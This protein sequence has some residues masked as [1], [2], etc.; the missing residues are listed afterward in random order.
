M[1]SVVAPTLRLKQ[2][3]SVSEGE[4]RV[5]AFARFLDNNRG[6]RLARRQTRPFWGENLLAFRNDHR[7]VSRAPSLLPADLVEHSQR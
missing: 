1:P 4:L 2:S 5:Q 6:A 7:I 3:Q